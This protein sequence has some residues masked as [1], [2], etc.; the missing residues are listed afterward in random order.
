MP[1]KK[2]DVNIQPTQDPLITQDELSGNRFSA[3]ATEENTDDDID[4]VLNEDE[5]YHIE[6]ETIGGN[7]D[8]SIH[9]DEETIQPMD[10]EM[11]LGQHLVPPPRGPS[12]DARVGEGPWDPR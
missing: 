9:E 12:R 3:F 10:Q 2:D 5:E 6:E 8:T 4:S 1:P 11:R 7:M